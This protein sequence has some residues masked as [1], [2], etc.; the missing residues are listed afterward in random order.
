MKWLHDFIPLTNTS[1]APLPAPPPRFGPD[2][3]TDA[4]L[5]AREKAVTEAQTIELDHL[6]IDDPWDGIH[7]DDEFPNWLNDEDEDDD[8]RDTQQTHDDIDA[9]SA[10]LRFCEGA[11]D[12]V[13]Q[14]IH[15]H[16]WVRPPLLGKRPIKHPRAGIIAKA[17][18]MVRQP[19]NELRHAGHRINEDPPP[20]PQQRIAQYQADVDDLL[21][22]VRAGPPARPVPQRL[23]R[24]WYR[25]NE[26]SECTF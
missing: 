23:N 6:I 1:H 20:D 10:H 8:R 3:P 13:I 25:P 9:I 11:E 19:G 14:N 2:P 26:D 12:T 16:P 21:E 17:K 7:S 4:W 15:D 18:Q 22:R 24:K 5:A